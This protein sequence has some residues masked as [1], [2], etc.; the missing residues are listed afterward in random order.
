[1]MKLSRWALLLSLFIF[2][3]TACTK[4]G[5][6][7]PIAASVAA[8][9]KVLNLYCWANYFSPDVIKRF[10]EK[11]K[12]K[13]NMDFFSSNEELLAKLQAGARGYDLIVP[14]AYLVK[15]LKELKLIVPLGRLDWPELQTLTSRFKAPDFDAT[16]EYTVPYS[17]G[18]TGIAVNRA[19]IKTKVDSLSWFFDHPELKGQ[20]TMLDDAPSVIGAALKYLGYPYNEGGDEAFAKVKAL[21]SK[22]KKF[23]KSYTPESQPVLESGEVAIAQAYSGDVLQVKNRKNPNI[24]F[25]LPKEGSELFVDSLAI[26]TGAPAPEL[27]KEF[28]RFT[29]QK[30]VA[31][32]QVKHLFFSPVVDIV[33]MPELGALADNIAV[34]PSDASLSKFEMMQENPERIEKIQRLWTELKSM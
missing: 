12:V 14:T 11:A 23:L 30:D 31:L 21:L 7:S 6:K 25:V 9:P 8:A 27:A 4:S 5:D 33:K 22:Q 1:M 13:V 17:W 24:D 29:L 19:K 20:V 32:I 26:P 10:E 34:F 16:H 28:M 3:V 2:S 15:A 18:T